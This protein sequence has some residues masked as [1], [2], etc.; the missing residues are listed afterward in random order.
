[1]LRLNP[2]R[3]NQKGEGMMDKRIALPPVK[4][5]GKKSQFITKTEW[6]ISFECVG[7]R[8][9]NR[10]STTRGDVDRAKEVT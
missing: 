1:M 5:P 7:E 8:E 2:N 10:I 6:G 3:R 9:Y 4:F